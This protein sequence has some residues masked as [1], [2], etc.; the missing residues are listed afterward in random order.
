MKVLIVCLVAC[1]APVGR[2]ALIEHE[3]GPSVTPGSAQ[4]QFQQDRLEFVVPL[5]HVGDLARRTWSTHPTLDADWSVQ[6]HFHI[7]QMS[8]ASTQNTAIGFELGLQDGQ[9]PSLAHL[10]LGHDGAF[11]RTVSASFKVFNVIGDGRQRSYEGA[12]V[13]L[14]LD[15]SASERLMRGRFQPPGSVLMDLFSMSV[16]GWHIPPGEPLDLYLA[17]GAHAIEITSNQVYMTDFSFV[18]EPSLLAWLGLVP[19]IA[20]G[21]RGQR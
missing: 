7:D 1:L 13:I 5:Q 9:P 18:P 4:L 14:N 19:F 11:G 10:S 6:G 2:A 20:R 3:W 12:D 8:L 21:V 16:E 17:G 15:Y